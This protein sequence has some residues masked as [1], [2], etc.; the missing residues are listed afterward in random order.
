[1]AT[2]VP[3]IKGKL[4]NTDY[5]IIAMKAKEL[6]EKST[7]PADMDDWEEMTLEEKYQR[8]INYGRVKKEIAPYFAK[9]KERFFGAIILAAKN[10]SSDSFESLSDLA[11]QGMGRLYQMQTKTMGFL[12][13]T[14]GEV[15]IPLDGQHRIKAIQFAIDG[16][17][18]RGKPIANM[19]PC[20][21]LADEDVTVILVKYDSKKSRKIFTRVNRYAKPTSAG[22]NLVTDDDDYIAI[23]ARVVANEVIGSD[24]V[25]TGSS[26]LSNTDS[27]FTTL[28][29]IAECNKY[30]LKEIFCI[31]TPQPLIV[32]APDLKSNYNKKIKEIW[33]HLTK[34]IK[35]F[36]S[37]LSDPSSDG[38]VERRK[39][40]ENNL[41]GKPVPQQYMFK[42]FV[43]LLNSNDFTKQEASD[44]LNKIDWRKDAPAWDHVLISGGRIVRNAILAPDLIYYMA[45]GKIDAEKEKD[46]LN[47]YRKLFPLDEQSKV[48][49]PDKV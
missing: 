27:F 15:L 35:R 13:L 36:A 2:T 5:F 16:C 20:S 41:L 21:D 42:A 31:P 10:F 23:S 45:G 11:L 37:M 49:L 17:D 14:G 4:G 26:T 24:L 38:D 30:V 8:D 32:E 3:A 48:K 40:R 9:D 47:R 44:A 19:S 18:E 46:L 1:M 25:K 28:A 7:I 12:T 29:T 33:E 39:I 22:Q 34:N 43:L 6:V